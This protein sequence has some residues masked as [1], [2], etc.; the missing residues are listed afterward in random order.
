MAIGRMD[1]VPVETG[2]QAVCCGTREVGDHFPDFA[3]A[4]GSRWV[5]RHRLG[6]TGKHRHPAG[7]QPDRAWSDGWR[8]IRPQAAMANAPDMP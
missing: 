8:T 2:C 6:T 4:Q 3:G 7:A 1:L 5:T